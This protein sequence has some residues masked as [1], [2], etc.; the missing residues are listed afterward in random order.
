MSEHTPGPWEWT[1]ED[2]SVMALYGPRGL[3]DHVLWSG[4]CTACQETGNR[5][6]A[7][8]DANARL[9]AMAPGLLE[10][11]EFY[12][13][14]NSYVG[15]HLKTGAELPIFEDYGKIARAAIAKATEEQP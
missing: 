12:A 9:I 7:P 1:M 10:A 5:C 15:V 11:L 4:I 13:A 8:N 3:E 14:E 2:A 6:T